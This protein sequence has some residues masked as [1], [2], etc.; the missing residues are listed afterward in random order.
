[1]QTKNIIIIAVICCAATAATAQESFHEFSIVAGGGLST[2][3]YKPAEG[4]A[5]WGFGGLAGLGYTFRFS[6]HWGIGTGVEA[7]LFTGKYSLTSLSDHYPSHDSEQDFD[8]HYT[9]SGYRD[10]QQ[11]ILLN[12]PLMLHFQTD[13]KM[14]NLV[15]LQGFYAA[16]GGK[17]GIPLSAKFNS[18]TNRLD[19][20]GVYPPPTLTL[21]DPQFMGFGEFAALNSKGS[22]A[23]KTAFF[24]SAEAGVRW[25]LNDKLSLSTGLYVDYGINNIRPSAATP[26][27]DY[28]GSDDYQPNSV[29]T[30]TNAG[31]PLVDK[32]NPLA[33]GI[34]VGLL[35]GVPSSDKA[36]KAPP[37]PDLAALEA[38]Q[39]R[40]AAEERRLAEERLLAEQK[41]AEEQRLAEETR[42]AEQKR[43]EEQRLV[44]VIEK[45]EQPMDAS[46]YG[47]YPL[48]GTVLSEQQ[49]AALDEK[50]ALILQ[51]Y[52]NAPIIIEG[53]T[54]NTGTHAI[55][56]QLSQERADVVKAYLVQKGIAANLITT[57]SKAA[58][59]P[60]V[61][62]DSE[63]NKRKNR[64]VVVMVGN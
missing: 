52:P 9:I 6:E 11:A 26:L 10:R 18:S 2:L 60:L 20:S 42:L 48:N 1:M 24:A 58:T 40:K 36:P 57:V 16:L 4:K 64:R 55:N 45:I 34:K 62:N 30:S 47:G 29:V 38:E 63:A 54:C 15:A 23:L 22:L 35:F 44:E 28:R 31:K 56:M 21:Y 17:V 59:E 43:S 13:I 19:A 61:P 49:K 51:H 32:L 50:A 12:I 8:Y 46:M 14:P 3:H 39:Q 53:H 27:I 5:K 25:R 37:E 41:R 33:A 7:A